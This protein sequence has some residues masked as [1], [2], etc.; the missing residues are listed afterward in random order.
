MPP[1]RRQT[2][3]EDMDRFDPLDSAFG[4]YVPSKGTSC[5]I[6]VKEIQDVME[7][8]KGSVAVIEFFGW[9]IT[10]GFVVRVLNRELVV[11]ANP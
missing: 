1:D 11:L 6:A 8:D 9:A 2:Y 4:D 3:F 10:R 7:Q 5:L